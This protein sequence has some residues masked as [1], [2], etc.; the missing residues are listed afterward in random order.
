ML[1]ETKSH[2]DPLLEA[3]IAA[4]HVHAPDS[5]A[6]HRPLIP[7]CTSTDST[8]N[9]NKNV[10]ELITAGHGDPLMKVALV[11]GRCASFKENTT[12]MAT[13]QDHPQPLH[14]DTEPKK[15]GDPLLQAVAATAVDLNHPKAD[16]EGHHRHHHPRAAKKH[17]PPTPDTTDERF[18][19]FVEKV[20]GDDLL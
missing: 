1:N 13:V 16:R 8:N 19:E 4:H 12:S 14:F 2:G 17:D 9:S 6:A 15:H 20:F 18:S 5:A 10:V 3:A 7:S 11:G